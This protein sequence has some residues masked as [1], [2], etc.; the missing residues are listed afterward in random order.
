MADFCRACSIEIFGEDHRELAEI[1]TEEQQAKGHYAV[2]I[3]EGCGIIQVDKDGNC[4]SKDC[5]KVLE[6]G[7]GVT[8]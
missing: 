2:V 3:C 5:L 6:P 8:P 7:H 4:V 1:T